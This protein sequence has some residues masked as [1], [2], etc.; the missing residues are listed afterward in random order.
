MK[1]L[2]VLSVLCAAVYSVTVCPAG[3][4]T[5]VPSDGA[6]SDVS[7]NEINDGSIVMV[8]CASAYTGDVTIECKGT[9]ASVKTQ[10]CIKICVAGTYRAVPADGVI[11]DV[12]Y[13]QLV[14]G[15]SSEVVCASDYTGSVTVLCSNGVA[16]FSNTCVRKICPASY[17]NDG[18]NNWIAH[19][20]IGSGS[21]VTLNCPTGATGSV[22]VECKYPTVSISTGSVG[23]T[24]QAVC[25][26]G[27]IDASGSLAC[28]SGKITNGSTSIA[29]CDGN[30]VG[31]VTV[32]CT[33]SVISKTGACVEA[34]TIS[35][36][37]TDL[38]GSIKLN[39]NIGNVEKIVTANTFSF[40]DVACC[41]AYAITI[42]QQ[43]ANQACTITNGEGTNLAT[44]ITNVK[45]ECISHSTTS[46][47][48]TV[49][50]ESSEAEDAGPAI[51][52]C[53]VLMIITAT[54][55]CGTF[56]YFYTHKDLANAV[57]RRMNAAR[58]Q[59]SKLNEDFDEQYNMDDVD[60]GK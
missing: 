24:V 42:A 21:N 28:W 53:V 32:S 26:A 17:V 13:G 11:S 8:S 29:V 12:S 6:M 1:F 55:C 10:T 37:I 58:K 60:Y 27:C 47:V 54:A 39:L 43:P 23:C 56:W 16:S 3:S 57:T 51:V 35:G 50:P 31:T 36:T 40:T 59:K 4:L 9:T 2:I 18:N 45:I 33:N 30:Y 49:E 34:K 15:T 19:A 14:A 52:A 20:D 22:K 25:E 7:H 46:V 41:Q 44:N 5:A 38:T 48:T